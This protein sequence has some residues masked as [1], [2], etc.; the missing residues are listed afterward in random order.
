MRYTVI[1]MISI[2]S[3]L[4]CSGQGLQDKVRI[5]WRR[6]YPRV[7]IMPN[8]SDGAIRTS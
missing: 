2:V 7:R 8:V 5:P 4:C 6:P 3:F 1:Y